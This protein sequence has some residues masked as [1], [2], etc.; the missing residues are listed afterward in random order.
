MLSK[1][2]VVALIYAKS[3]LGAVP[4]GL[5]SPQKTGTTTGFGATGS[6]NAAMEG[7]VNGLLDMNFGASPS[8]VSGSG[9]THEGETGSPHLVPGGDA[10][11]N[12]HRG[13]FFAD[14]LPAIAP[15]PR[16]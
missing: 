15:P 13:D 10:D 2:Q 3:G 11:T 6:P 8:W 14:K 12:S 7:V 1:K 16:K 5:G 9:S 4:A